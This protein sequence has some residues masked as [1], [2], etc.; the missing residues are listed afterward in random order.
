[1][2][3]IQDVKLASIENIQ[4]EKDNDKYSYL[5]YDAETSD[6]ISLVVTY[7][8]LLFFRSY[9]ISSNQINVKVISL[10]LLPT[11]FCGIL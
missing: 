11:L 6:S 3:H 4:A 9:I 10:A 5:D 1:M 2:S 7:S 8:I